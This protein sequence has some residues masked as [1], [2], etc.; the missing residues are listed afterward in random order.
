MNENN[1]AKDVAFTSIISK[2][3]F[4]VCDSC[5]KTSRVMKLRLPKTK[6]FDRKNISTEYFNYW[7]CAPCRTKLV[8][9]LDNPEE[10][11]TNG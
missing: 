7:L 6:Y 2:S 1:Y 5:K 11:K 3:E 4:N 9:A 10:E 8:Y